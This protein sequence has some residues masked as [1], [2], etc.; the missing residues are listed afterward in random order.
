MFGIADGDRPDAAIVLGQ[1]GQSGYFQRLRDIWPETR[2]IEEHTAL[3]Q[4]GGRQIWVTVVFGASM[5]ATITHF[6]VTLGARAVIQIGSMGGLAPGWSIGDILVPSLVIG[7]D[8]VSRQLSR[9]KAIEPDAELSGHLREELSTRLPDTT[10]RSGTLVSTTTISLE[11]HRDIGR[12]QR[13]GFA[14]VEMECAATMS[15]AR[16]FGAAVAGAFVLIDNVAEGHAF[17]DLTDGEGA[18][19]RAAQDATLRASV[20]SALRHLG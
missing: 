4:T 12:W 11:R 15:T 5:A 20:E 19:I 10:I 6:A 2:E 16:H 13:S 17:Y 9:N 3:I 1:W 18:R 7:R 8:G 14:G